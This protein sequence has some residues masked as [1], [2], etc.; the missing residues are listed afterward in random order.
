MTDTT[1]TTMSG[2]SGL[3]RALA[4]NRGALIA[5]AVFALLLGIVSLR[6]V[7]HELRRTGSLNLF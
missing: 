7:D 5:A 3:R 4:K 1:L 6:R 2:S